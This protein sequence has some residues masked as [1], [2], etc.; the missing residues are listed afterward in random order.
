MVFLLFVV[1]KVFW[2]YMSGGNFIMKVYVN[3]AGI[4]NLT[5]T[6]KYTWLSA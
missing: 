5:E 2:N 4:E 6:R 1:K 3:K